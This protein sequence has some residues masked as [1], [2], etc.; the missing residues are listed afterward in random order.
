MLHGVSRGADGLRH[1]V[2]EST[3]GDRSPELGIV[4]VVPGTVAVMRRRNRTGRR[5]RGMSAGTSESGAARAAVGGGESRCCKTERA[6]RGKAC[7]RSGEFRKSSHGGLL[8][9]KVVGSS[10]IR[11]GAERQ[12][13]FVWKRGLTKESTLQRK[14]KAIR[15]DERQR[16]EIEAQ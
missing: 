6:G 11:R 15:N 9:E 3:G 10:F 13:F 16:P 2:N 5:R 1:A 7:D 14:A 4:I 8:A 12:E